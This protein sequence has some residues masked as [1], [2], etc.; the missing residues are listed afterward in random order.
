VLWCSKTG[1]SR[2]N[3]RIMKTAEE[4]GVWGLDGCLFLI[5][6][7]TVL[8]KNCAHIFSSELVFC[9]FRMKCVSVL[10]HSVTIPP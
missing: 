4:Y 8:D 5:R 2:T 6:K 1:V 10:M 9:F 7:C 3:S